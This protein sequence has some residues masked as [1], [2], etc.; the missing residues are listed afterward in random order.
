MEAVHCMAI[1]EHALKAGKYHALTVEWLEFAKS[2]I[3]ST[4]QIEEVKLETLIHEAVA[5]VSIFYKKAVF[6]FQF[7]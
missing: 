6:I 1:G 3:G 2:L 4:T 5:T 7:L